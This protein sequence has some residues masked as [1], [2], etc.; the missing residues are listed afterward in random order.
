MRVPSQ[1]LTG[2][3]PAQLRARAAAKINLA[4]QVGAVREDGYHEVVTVLQAV[5][6]WDELEVHLVP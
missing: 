6:L 4:L 1:N 2:D 5:G 3:S